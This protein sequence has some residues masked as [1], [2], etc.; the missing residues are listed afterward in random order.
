MAQPL[1]ILSA[2]E[3]RI[4]KRE[5]DTLTSP[6]A[7]SKRARVDRML[8]GIRKQPSRIVVERARLITASFHKTEGAPVA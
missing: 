7:R 5:D 8:R 3:E 6:E 2:Q 4:T 1:K